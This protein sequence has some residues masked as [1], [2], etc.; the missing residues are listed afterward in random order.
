MK[1]TITEIV[2]NNTAQLTHAQNGKIYY[3]IEVADD[4]YSFPVD[5]SDRVEVGDA[6]F[7]LSEKAIYLTRYI[8]MA[9]E[10]GELRVS[11]NL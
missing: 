5:I 11:S 8:R 4:I 9:Q 3:K 10:N 7:K 2:K 1:H 6:E